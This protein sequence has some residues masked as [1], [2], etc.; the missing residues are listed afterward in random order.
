MAD[1]RT[2]FESASTVSSAAERDVAA[3]ISE[4]R[5]RQE[6]LGRAAQ[7]LRRA[8]QGADVESARVAA[9]RSSLGRVA[10]GMYMSGSGASP[11]DQSRPGTTSRSA[12]VATSGYLRAVQ[13]SSM[14]VVA[15]ARDVQAQAQA[16]VDQAQADVRS[17]ALAVADGLAATLRLRVAA[18]HAEYVRQLAQD[19]YQAALIAQAPITGSALRDIERCDNRLARTLFAAGFRGESLHQAWAIVMR[20]SGGRP[21]A[22]SATQDYG[23]FQF[24]RATYSDQYWWSDTRLLDRKYNA[25]IAYQVSQRGTTWTPWGLDG[26]GRVRPRVYLN[27]GWT[28]QQVQDRIV[29]PFTHWYALFP[30]LA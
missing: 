24:N 7:S 26:Q 29:D 13:G 2:A 9:A 30:C 1:A 6:A 4:V 14:D 5:V 18:A 25:F 11:A 22:I 10:R 27:A 23:L 19:G 8:Q 15:R 20:E 21:D 17:A 3:A 28:L 12:A 16:R